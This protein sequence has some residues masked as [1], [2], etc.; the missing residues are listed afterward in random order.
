MDTRQAREELTRRAKAMSD[1]LDQ[2]AE[3]QGEVKELKAEAKADGYDMKA[4]G[5]IIKEMRRGPDFQADQLS[6]ELVIDTYRV[7][8][9]LP[10]DL[11]AAQDAARADAAQVPAKRRES[12][13]EQV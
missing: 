2:I 12:A 8:V 10:T 7:A 9:G 4:F 13:L 1:L 3:L 6:L 11:E 5:Q